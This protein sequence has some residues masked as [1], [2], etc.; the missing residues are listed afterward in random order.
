MPSQPRTIK[1]AAMS[2]IDQ[3]IRLNQRDVF[4]KIDDLKSKLQAGPTM[5][6]YRQ[7]TRTSKTAQVV[8]PKCANSLIVEGLSGISCG[9]DTA[10]MRVFLREN[11]VPW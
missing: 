9:L 8:S 4:T 5:A 1:A 10:I 11:L 3:G 7:S 2:G 6:N